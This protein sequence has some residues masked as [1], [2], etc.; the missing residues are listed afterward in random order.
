[1]SHNN[2][3]AHSFTFTSTSTSTTTASTSPPKTLS[4]AL[5]NKISIFE[6]EVARTALVTAKF[7][8]INECRPDLSPPFLTI[9]ENLMPILTADWF[10]EQQE[11]LK[12]RARKVLKDTLGLQVATDWD[13]AEAAMHKYNLRRFL[14]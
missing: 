5:N 6:S 10:E 9:Y 11:C 8:K 2:Q 4:E 14:D 13:G 7:R 1:M 3:R 12:I